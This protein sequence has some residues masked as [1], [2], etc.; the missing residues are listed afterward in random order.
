MDDIEI[1]RDP[2]R[3]SRMLPSY[4]QNTAEKIDPKYMEMTETELE[5]I[6][7]PDPVT[8]RIRMAFW[9]AYEYAEANYE[10]KVNLAQIAARVGIPMAVVQSHMKNEHKLVWILCPPSSYDSF[11]DEAL[12]YGLRRLRNDIL[13]MDIYDPS[14]SVD[15]KKADLL[16]KAI[17]FVDLRKHG[18]TVDRKLHIHAS[19][20]DMKA[21]TKQSMDLHEIEKRIKELEKTGTVEDARR[22]VAVEVLDGE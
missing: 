5:P 22:A 12:D 16:L 10:D 15:I 14:G 20:K 7:N 3:H 11:L 9:N 2:W 13:T 4:V 19:S 18:G 21:I 8:N 1:Y 6:V 17:A